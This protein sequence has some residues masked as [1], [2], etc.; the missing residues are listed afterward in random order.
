MVTHDTAVAESCERTIH[1]RDGKIFE[2]V[3]RVILLRLLSWPYARKYLL[4]CSLTIL[5]RLSGRHCG[6][7][8]VRIGI[9]HR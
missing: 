3:R 1:I 7:R 6:A 5:E 2:D 9:E 4:R 8:D